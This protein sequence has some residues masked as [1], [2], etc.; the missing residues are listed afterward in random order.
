MYNLQVKAKKESEL[1]KMTNMQEITVECFMERVENFI[2][3]YNALRKNN[4]ETY[5]AYESKAL[6]LIAKL[7]KDINEQSKGE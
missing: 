7:A 3:Q 4:V 2:E 5:E 1:F 6:D